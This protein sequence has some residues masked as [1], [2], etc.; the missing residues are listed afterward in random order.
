MSHCYQPMSSLPEA[1]SKKPLLLAT[2]CYSN[3]YQ[4]ERRLTI[5]DRTDDFVI[6]AASPS[7]TSPSI[8][9]LAA[10]EAKPST[11]RRFPLLSL[12]QQSFKLYLSITIRAILDPTATLAP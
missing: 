2:V 7:E 4:R 6:S 3:H 8:L 5:L 1:R 10:H 11:M 9:H 12:H